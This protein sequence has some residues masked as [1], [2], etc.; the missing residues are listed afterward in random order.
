MILVTL[1]T[2][3][4]SAAVGRQFDWPSW[5]IVTIP[6]AVFGALH[7][8]HARRAQE[9]A[10][11][12][13][14]VAE[15]AAHLYATGGYQHLADRLRLPTHPPRPPFMGL[16][17]RR[18][19]RRRGYVR[20]NPQ[21]RIRRQPL[22]HYLAVLVL[23][24]EG[25]NFAVIVAPVVGV[26]VRDAYNTIAQRLDWVLAPL[27]GDLGSGQL[28]RGEM[29]RIVHADDDRVLVFMAPDPLIRALPRRGSAALM[30]A[31]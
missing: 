30:E 12:K 15:L 16:W 18:L 31:N 29:R 17:H 20:N 6:V 7:A 3:A 8:W 24:Q 9:L 19:G 11:F 28:R 1:V 14:V 2:A 21:W 27:E 4:L 13:E 10:N 22:R 26:S 23:R 5:V 25:N